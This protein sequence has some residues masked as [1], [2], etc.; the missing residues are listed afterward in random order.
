MNHHI[1]CTF[2]QIIY[3][4]L[5]MSQKLHVDDF[6]RRKNMSKFNETF[7]EN[8]DKDSAKVD[9]EYLKRLHNFHNNLPFLS[10]I[11]KIK[12]CNKLECNLYEKTTMM[13]I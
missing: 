2:M 11:I 9:V 6:K 3:K 10:E 12:K 13:H 1:L 4:Y 8:Y 5:F 7:I